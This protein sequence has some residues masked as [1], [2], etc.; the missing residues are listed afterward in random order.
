VDHRLPGPENPK[1]LDIS[2]FTEMIS[3][4]C[5]ERMFPFLVGRPKR[6]I[7]GSSRYACRLREEIKQAASDAVRKPVLITGEPGL[8]KDNIAQLVHFGSADRRLPLMQLDASEMHTNGIELF[9]REEAS[10][11]SLLKCLANGNLLI[12]CIDLAN[13]Q[14]RTR[15]ISLA[16]E[17]NLDF[18]GRVFFTAESSVKELDGIVTKIK[19][20]PLR[21][22]RSDLGDW[23]SYYI[24]QH[25]K[26]QGWSNVPAIP[27]SVIKR[28]QGHDFPNNLRELENIVIRALRQSHKYQE[29]NYNSKADE[30]AKIKL[31]P[32]EVF[33]VSSR[34]LARSPVNLFWKNNRDPSLRFDIWRWKPEL[35]HLMRS[36]RLWNT[37]LFGFVSWLFVFA[38]VELWLGPQDRAHNIV[39]KFFWAWWWPLMLLLYPLVGRLW[40][41][42]CPFMVWGE[43]IQNSKRALAKLISTIGLP[44]NWLKP[45]PWPHGNQDSWGTPFIAAGFAVILLWE[46]VWNLPDSARLS[47]SLLLLITAAS[48]LCS[49]L[50]EK[51]FWCR[52]LC[53][54]GGMN[55]LFSKLSML[56][57]R[58]EKGTCMGSCSSY[59]CY[60]GGPAEGEGMK[61]TGCPLG[62]HPAN[63]ID[64][65]NCVLCMTCDQ[66]CPHQSVQLRLRPPAADLQRTMHP[67]DGEKW[68]ILVLVGG[69]TLHYWYRFLGWLPLAPESLQ[70]G[71]LLPRIAFGIL[72]LSLPTIACFWI[73]RRW[74]YTALPLLWGVLL[75]RHLPLGMMEGGTVLPLSFPQWVAD[76]HV[77][78]FCQTL[79]IA[80]GWIGSV[81]LLRRLIFNRWS[82]CIPGVGALLVVSLA[83]AWLVHSNVITL[84]SWN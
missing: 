82:S 5:A 75:A 40:C 17:S 68:L 2:S 39:L 7:V 52:Y 12:N 43:I 49:F 80:L 30:I 84:Y 27:Q 6:G 73:E 14:L 31:L 61:T 16:A 47:S 51:R 72:A 33:W 66:A 65:R 22:R 78:G 59:A 74:L 24:R 9:G 81:I 32:E 46:E 45:M 37:F 76:I 50:F 28:L 55:G 36:P 70:Y 41:A 63:L 64:N 53:P 8:D 21:V 67:P 4:S 69:I 11:P 13:P 20:S 44:A 1:G 19:V 62:I 10:Q 56:E 35:R 25:S 54:V 23:L 58:A 42:V 15:L 71:P 38:N 48:M 79:A 3:R 29:I 77:I 26:R 34:H 57:L 18:H 83:G 60:K